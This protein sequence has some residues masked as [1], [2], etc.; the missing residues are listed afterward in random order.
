MKTHLNPPEP[1]ANPALSQVVVVAGLA[2]PRLLIEID[3]V[4]VA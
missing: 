3:A 1:A 2:D 4:A